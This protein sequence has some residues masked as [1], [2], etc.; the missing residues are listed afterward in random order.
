MEERGGHVIASSNL[1]LCRQG[2]LRNMVSEL[3]GIQ[4]NIS[5]ANVTDRKVQ[6]LAAYINKETPTGYFML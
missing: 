2:E 3:L 4:F 1:S 5:K 6:N